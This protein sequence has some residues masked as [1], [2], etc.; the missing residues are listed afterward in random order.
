M[1]EP[2]IYQKLEEYSRSDYYPFHMPGHKRRLSGQMPRELFERDITEIDGFDN[3]HEPEGIILQAQQ[4][5]SELYGSDESFYLVGGS[6]CGI[7]SAISAAVPEGG[8]LLADR[9]CHRSVYHAAY[10][11]NLELSY[12]Y[13]DTMQDCDIHEAVNAGAVEKAL[14]FD[15]DSM[16]GSL[17]LQNKLPDAVLV[18]SPTYEGRIADIKRI[19][20]ITHQKGI[21]LI[22]DEAHGSHLGFYQGFA[23]NSCQAGAD[24]V[25][26]S[27]HKTLPAMTQA[28]LLHVKGDLINR[29][30]LRRYLKIYQS[31]SPSYVLM[32]SIEN[33]LDQVARN[34]ESLFGEF[35]RRWRKMLERLSPCRRLRFFTDEDGRQDIG[36]LV[37][38]AG[39][40]GLSGQQ[41]YDILLKKYHLQLEMASTDHV[42]AMFTIGD[43]EEGF[44][45]M[46]EA[47]LEIDQELRSEALREIPPE[48]GRSAGN[49]RL[50]KA[51]RISDVWDGS[52]EWLPPARCVGRIAGDFINLYPPG[53]PL[54][55]PGEVYTEEILEYIRGCF[56]SGLKV[57]GIIFQENELRFPVTESGKDMGI[58]L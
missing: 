47:L 56:L 22:V 49:F 40:T 24:L 26:H 8:R 5:A 11:R 14:T 53:V 39:K 15:A 51:C 20:D 32:S 27:V 58:T 46:T 41:L 38:L 54:V 57:Q 4:K 10:L 21:P 42:L 52:K 17:S 35:L 1:Q 43:T 33:A 34:R 9:R 37:I 48:N 28:A 7:L 29:E 45:R 2:N 23:C 19:A 13:S 30:R 18:T 25:I 55:V 36:K 3:L 16:E 44:R 50:Q 6:T 31:S 12:L